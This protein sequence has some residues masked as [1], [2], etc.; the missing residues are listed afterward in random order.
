[1][2]DLAREF[3]AG[4]GRSSKWEALGKGWSAVVRT[5]HRGVSDRGEGAPHGQRGNGAGGQHEDWR[6]RIWTGDG[7]PGHGG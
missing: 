3:D 7:V 2:P 5:A 1:V 4:D 6:W